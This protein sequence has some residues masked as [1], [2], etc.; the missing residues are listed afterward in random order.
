MLALKR[1]FNLKELTLANALKDTRKN[2]QT[3]KNKTNFF[4]FLNTSCCAFRPSPVT[5]NR[6]FP[7]SAKENKMLSLSFSYF[8]LDIEVPPFLIMLNAL[9]VIINSE[10]RERK[11][12]IK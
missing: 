7:A 6:I 4:S 3:I 12:K 2:L 5:T 9:C 1:V 10:R 11:E 8:E